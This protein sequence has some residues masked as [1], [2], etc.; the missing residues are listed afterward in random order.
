MYQASENH[1]TK[2]GCRV[3]AAFFY[4]L[5]FVGRI[6]DAIRAPLRSVAAAS[7]DL[8]CAAKRDRWC[9]A[10]AAPAG[11]PLGRGCADTVYF[12]LQRFF[13]LVG[14]RLRCAWLTPCGRSTGSWPGFGSRRG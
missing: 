13:A 11:D 8:R 2:K 1:E 7:S 9:V 6:S 12:T 5:D 14:T 3:S 10:G 4:A